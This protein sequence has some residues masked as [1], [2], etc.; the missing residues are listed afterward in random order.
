[1]SSR[2]EEVVQPASKDKSSAPV[3][4]KSPLHEQYTGLILN[5]SRYQ[6][7]WTHAGGSVSELS[8]GFIPG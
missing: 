6:M 1:M 5:L 7:P 8:N 2:A 4:E 3:I